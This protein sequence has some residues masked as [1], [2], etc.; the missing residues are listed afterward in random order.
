MVPKHYKNFDPKRVGESG[1]LLK[2]ALSKK[3]IHCCDLC[4]PLILFSQEFNGVL[5]YNVDD[6]HWSP[7]GN[8]FVASFILPILIRI[9]KQT[10]L[11]PN[12]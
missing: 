5:L 4:K 6:L 11:N 12:K 3:N 10:T 1:K 9:S 7:A 8:K 2:N